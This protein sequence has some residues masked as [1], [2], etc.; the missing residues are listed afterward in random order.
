MVENENKAFYIESDDG[1][2]YIAGRD[3]PRFKTRCDAVLIVSHLSK[4]ATYDE[5]AIIAEKYNVYL[6]GS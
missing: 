1:L 3:S 4:H 2:W 6:I 5:I